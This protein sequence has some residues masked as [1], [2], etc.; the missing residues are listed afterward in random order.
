MLS[1]LFSNIRQI[2]TIIEETLREKLM[3]SRRDTTTGTSGIMKLSEICSFSV[4][5]I[6]D[7]ESDKL[8]TFVYNDSEKTHGDNIMLVFPF[9]DPKDGPIEFPM[10]YNEEKKQYTVSVVRPKDDGTRFLITTAQEI[11]KEE[12]INAPILQDGFISLKEGKQ[13][14]VN[15]LAGVHEGKLQDFLLKVDGTIHAIEEGQTN[16]MTLKEGERYIKIYKPPGYSSTKEPPYNLQIT[17]DGGQYLWPMKMDVV[18]DNLIAQNDIQPVVAVFISPH[19]GPPNPAEKEGFGLVMPKGYPLSMRGKEYCCNPEYADSVAQLSETLRQQFNVT[20]DPQHTTIWGLSAS[21][22]QAEYTALLHPEVFGN[23]VAQSPM[24]F[25][26]P[27]QN[28]ENWRENISHWSSWTT[29]LPEQEAQ[30]NEYITET[31]RTGY[32]AISKRELNPNGLPLKMYLDA[33]EM[34]REYNPA[35]GSANLVKATEV[36]ADALIEKG[37]TVVDN[38]VHVIPGGHHTMTWMRNIADAAKSVHPPLIQLENQSD[39]STSYTGPQCKCSK[40]K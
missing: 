27:I 15:R 14:P 28:G 36:F 19:S 22:L 34:E 35:Q 23:V 2:C 3:Q 26:I 32:D 5:D 30:H 12:N 16:L 10:T 39:A 29:P 40:I 38:H 1:E 33:G 24:A 20:S 37:H 25:N 6:A 17:L 31:L 11:G 21:G 9:N 4:E 8:I 13:Q 7:N 18:L